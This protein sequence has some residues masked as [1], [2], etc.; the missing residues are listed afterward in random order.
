MKYYAKGETDVF[1]INVTLLLSGS[2]KDEEVESAKSRDVTFEVT[3]KFSGKVVSETS[4]VTNSLCVVIISP[5]TYLF[6]STYL[7][8]CEASLFRMRLSDCGLIPK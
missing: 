8:F 7:G 3:G 4:G 2:C 5:P 1:F 6:S